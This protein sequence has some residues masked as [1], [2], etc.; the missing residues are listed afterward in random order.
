MTEKNHLW[1]ILFVRINQ[2]TQPGNKP[3]NLLIYQS[4]IQS[5]NNTP[6]KMKKSKPLTD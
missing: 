2:P 3:T 4:K 1:F 6:I 5:T